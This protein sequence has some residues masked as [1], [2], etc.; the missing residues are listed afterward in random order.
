MYLDTFGFRKPPFS[1]TPDPDFLFMSRDHR[2]ALA[3]LLFGIRESSGFVQLTGEVGTGKTTLCRYLLG[4]VP[5][6]VDVALILNPRQT[7]SELLSSICDELKIGYP[8][9]CR[10]IKLLVDRLNR[11]L[12]KRHAEGR[13]TVLI[14]DEA[15]NLAP[16]VLEQIRLLTNLETATTKLLQVLLI[17]QPELRA[18]MRRPDLRQLSQRIIGRYHLTPL[19]RDETAAYVRHRLRVAGCAADLFTRGAHR[20]IYRRSG[21]IPRL[22]NV[23]CDRAL[24]G[25]FARRKPRIDGTLVRAA[26]LDIQ[27][28]RARD[29]IRRSWLHRMVM[30]GAATV[31]AGMLAMAG[32]YAL[33]AGGEA[34][35]PADPVADAVPADLA[36]GT[37][38]SISSIPRGPDGVPEPAS[39]VEEIKSDGSQSQEASGGSGTAETESSPAGDIADGTALS[40]WLLKAGARS[41]PENAFATLLSYW[42]LESGRI[43]ETPGCVQAMLAGLECVQMSGELDALLSINRPAVME[44]LDGDRG[45]HHL[46]LSEV[47][48]RGL[49]LDMGG[50]RRT[51][52]AEAVAAF[53]TGSFTLL[54]RPPPLQRDRLQEGMEGADVL[55]LRHRLDRVQG[56]PPVPLDSRSDSYFDRAL[57]DRVMA[58]QRMRGITVD[59]IVGI[60]TLLE[61]DSAAGQGEVPVL[62]A[63]ASGGGEG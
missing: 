52:A 34:V 1:L 36:A 50:E 23:L 12:L 20:A 45:V 48:S 55:W 56:L 22:V 18:V 41:M 8:E 60:R 30:A 25:A 13:R 33:R 5:E 49:V 46:V 31:L 61:I 14:I 10:S 57:T 51:A 11:Y 38:T 2:D 62:R 19:S 54:W 43:P 63:A 37:V 4:R 39:I 59:G 16:E 40:R 6:G 17:G 35:Q 58:F 53:W 24:L 26:D 21:G 42:N 27:G 47:N 29:P 3:H 15:Q 44:F 28:G 9:G 7:A 32:H